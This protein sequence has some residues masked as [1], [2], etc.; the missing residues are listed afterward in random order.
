MP[1]E[2]RLDQAYRVARMHYEGGRTMESIAADLGISRST[3]SRLLR[4]AREEGIVRISL[5]PPQRGRVRDLAHRIGDRYRVRCRIV[6]T[7]PDSDERRRL[8]LV[9]SAAAAMI[10]DLLEP[11][12]Q[13]GLAWGTTVAAI[14]EELRPRPVPG[15][16]VVQLNGAIGLGGTGQTYVSTMLGRAAAT[17]DAG[18]DAFPVPAFFDYA[19]T[20]EAMWQERSVRR[21]LAAQERC[22]LAVFGVGAFDAEVPSRAY[23]SGYLTDAD[24]AELRADA[25]VGDI[26][27]VFLRA[28]GT[29]R[30][31]GMNARSSGTDP[32][33]LAK[34]PQRI[35]VAAG[36]RKAVPL[37]AAL[38]S[39]AATDL[40]ID[41]RTAA[42]LQA[43]DDA[44]AARDYSASPTSTRCAPV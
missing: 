24:R 9:A 18:I 42:S 20:R 5:H 22:T 23:T 7:D 13:L 36:P 28:D 27:T 14:V 29:W 26:A 30:G 35:L 15:M 12:T 4:D 25:A 19:A 11:D 2:T 1:H 44:G 6:G 3:V 37:R 33:R 31:I 38:L 32:A 10:D 39:G 21:V 34:V 41:E 8:Q 17:W 43:L 40:V 16:R